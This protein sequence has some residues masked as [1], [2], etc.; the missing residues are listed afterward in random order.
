MT[1]AYSDKILTA[2]RLGSF[3]RLLFYWKGSVYKLI[4]LEVIIYL[5]VYFFISMIYRFAL[6]DNKQK[7]Y[8][9]PYTANSFFA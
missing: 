7:R 4:W 6:E 9:Y 3:T 2:N 8:T 1:V 5:F